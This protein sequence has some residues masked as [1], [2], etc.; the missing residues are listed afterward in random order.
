M[1][2]N[3]KVAPITVLGYSLL[4]LLRQEPQSGYDLLR[5]F[6]TTPL[7]TYSDS[8]GAIYP[9]LD[10]LQEQR[11]IRSKVEKGAGLRRRR[12][13]HATPKGLAAL[14]KW[15]CQPVTQAEVVRSVDQ[16]LMRFSLMDGAVGPA[17]SLRLLK[18]MERELAGFATRLRKYLREKGPSMPLSGRLALDYGV[19]NYDTLVR[20]TRGAIAAYRKQQRRSKS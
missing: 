9:A 3:V 17:G 18:E 8:P 13:F 1:T 19:R 12:V 10:R 5:L 6:S 16:L 11:L 14:R 20:W 15:L 2:R 4:G 7:M